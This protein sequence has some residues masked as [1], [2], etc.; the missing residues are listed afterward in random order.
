MIATAS[1]DTTARLWNAATGETLATLTG[2]E[3]PL[4]AVAFSPDGATAI[5]A[6]DDHTARLWNAATGKLMVSLVGHRDVVQ[7][8]AFSPDGTKI[9]TASDDST[10]RLWDRA[11]GKPLATLAGHT[12]AVKSALFS[13]DGRQVATASDDDTARLWDVHWITQY[14]GRDLIAAVC[15]EKLIGARLV[16]E[17]DTQVSSILASR[18]GEDVCAPAS[19][20]PLMARAVGFAR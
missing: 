10:A 6:S 13:P 16:T 11:T 5:T 8:A 19:W 12:G 20:L 18:A 15:R 3:G 17:A 4:R 14:H 9:L 7:S 2:H 1:D